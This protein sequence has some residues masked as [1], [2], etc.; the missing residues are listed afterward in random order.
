MMANQANT[1][2]YAFSKALTEIMGQNHPRRRMQTPD[3]IDQWNLDKSMAFYKDRF[4]DASDFTFVFVG[5]I[6]LA[7]DEAAGRALPRQPAVD[8]A[9]GDVEGRRGAD[10]DGRDCEAGGE[11]HRAQEPD[12]DALHRAV[13]VHAGTARRDSRDD[14]D[15]PEPAARDH[16]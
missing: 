9:E 13:R 7:D 6:D 10:A 5:N 2:G 14:G 8:P 16:S 4:A 3:M 11:G 12:G 1:P 15:S